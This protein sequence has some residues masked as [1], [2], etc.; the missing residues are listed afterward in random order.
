MG[1]DAKTAGEHQVVTAGE[2]AHETASETESTPEVSTGEGAGGAS[3][4]KGKNAPNVTR[5]TAAIGIG[6]TAALL[7]FGGLRYIGHNPVKRPPGG[8]DEA[9]LV[10]A[11]IRCERC[12]AAC[13]HDVI[14]PAHIEDGLLGMRSPELEFS[15]NSPGN[16][17]VLQYC[18]FCAEA[19]N[20]VPRCVEV[21]PTEALWLPEGATAD[22]TV[23]GLA[24]I[25]TNQCMAYRDTGCRFCY[26]ACVKARGEEKAAIYLNNESAMPRP[27]VDAEKC[28]GCGACESICV[29]L[30]NG[31]IAAGATQRA[32]VVEPLDV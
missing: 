17:N 11:C 2:T 20:G 10:S 5:R 1:E 29:S 24:V 31:S 3:K 23:I 7:V 9:A 21:C 19:N 14:V 26:D 18:D 15:S 30:Q 13:P 8:Q 27:V 25:D 16:V 6:S 28:N 4:G 12:S 22:N 32:I